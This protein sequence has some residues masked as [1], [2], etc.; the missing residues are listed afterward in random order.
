MTK[1]KFVKR[2][3]FIQNFQSEQQTLNVL[4]DKLTD[5]SACVNFGYSLIDEMIDMI[6]EALHIE[7]DD[8]IFW[9]LYEDVDKVIYSGDDFKTEIPV[10]TPAELYDYIVTSTVLH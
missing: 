7:D 9:W 5:G 1:E 8:L 10:R 4:I 2:L 3:G 6:N